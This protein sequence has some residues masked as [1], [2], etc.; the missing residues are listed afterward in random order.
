MAVEFLIT[1]TY[2]HCSLELWDNPMTDRIDVTW[3]PGDRFFDTAQATNTGSIPFGT[4]MRPQW[5]APS[6]A[7]RV[8]GPYSSPPR[9]F[10]DCAYQHG[11]FTGSN[12]FSLAV[13]GKATFPPPPPP[14]PPPAPPPP[15]R[16]LT[17]Q[18]SAR[19]TYQ[20]DVVNTGCWDARVKLLASGQFIAATQWIPTR[21]EATAPPK[22]FHLLSPAVD[23]SGVEIFPV[24][25][26]GL[27]IPVGTLTA[28]LQFAPVTPDPQGLGP[29]DGRVE[30]TLIAQC[31][32]VR[33]HRPVW[34][35]QPGAGQR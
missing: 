22:A 28:R 9:Y 18:W 11:P 16:P 14:P 31:A 23:A 13:W 32:P 26:T 30:V 7:R 3:A 4:R 10:G 12:K 2:I 29:F 5:S 15:P 8:F 20:V 19:F 1:N 33:G 17:L 6:S 21:W 34:D 27:P 25:A 24:P 35:E